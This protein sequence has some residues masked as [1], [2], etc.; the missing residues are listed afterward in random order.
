MYSNV[1]LN[2][3]KIKDGEY[4]FERFEHVFDILLGIAADGPEARGGGGRS[5]GTIPIG[6]SVSISKDLEASSTNPLFMIQ[7]LFVPPGKYYFTLRIQGPGLTFERFKVGH[8]VQCA[9]SFL[10]LR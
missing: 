9:R 3:K 6:V 4:S 7:S 10:V 2:G 5:P 1:L 8:S